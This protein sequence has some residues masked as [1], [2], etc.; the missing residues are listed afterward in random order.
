MSESILAEP[1]AE[2]L[3]ILRLVARHRALPEDK[4]AVVQRLR[5]RGWIEACYL[6]P[7]GYELTFVGLRVLAKERA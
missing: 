6:D 3:E 5:A 2:D 1:T 4:R 7:T